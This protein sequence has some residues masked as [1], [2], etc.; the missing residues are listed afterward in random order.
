MGY[1]DAE[2]EAEEDKEACPSDKEVHDDV[3][4]IAVQDDVEDKE[5][6]PSDEAIAVHDDVEAACPRETDP[7]H[8]GEPACRAELVDIAAT[9]EPGVWL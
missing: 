7:E 6:C 1:G 4:A 9:S 2:Q 5:A 8:D 3:E